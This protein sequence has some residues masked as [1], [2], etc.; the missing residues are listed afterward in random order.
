MAQIRHRP[1]TRKGLHCCKPL[2]YLARPAGFEPTNIPLEISSVCS[3]PKLVVASVL[4]HRPDHPHYVSSKCTD[5]L[6][7][8]L[9][10]GA[11]L[12]IENA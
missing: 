4:E 9:A 11:F 12:L 5:S 1:E 2:C 8:G 7:M 6:V 3:R 10:L